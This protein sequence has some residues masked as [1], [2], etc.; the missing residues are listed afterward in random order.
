MSMDYNEDFKKKVE[1]PAGERDKIVNRRGKEF[2]P[3]CFHMVKKKINKKRNEWLKSVNDIDKTILALVGPTFFNPFRS[4][5]P[6]Y[7]GLQALFLLGAND[8]HNYI[9]IHD[10][11]ENIMSSITVYNPK[12][13][14]TKS[15]W[16]RFLNRPERENAVHTMDIQGRIHGNF[17]TMQRLGGYN[18]YGYKLQQLGCCID[19]RKMSH[20]D[21]GS[22]WVYCLN[23]QFKTNQ[24][25]KPLYDSKIIMMRTD[26]KVISPDIVSSGA[27]KEEEVLEKVEGE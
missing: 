15:A 18:P 17:R 14:K 21:L 2:V 27:P 7:G 24:D 23:T 9:D 5:G 4:G 12:D 10:M 26:K 16:E 3:R 22:E 8:Y 25:V 6:Y 1:K 20:P 11:M 13:K 19:I